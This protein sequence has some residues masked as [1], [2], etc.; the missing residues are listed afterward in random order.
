MATTTGPA[1]TI[2]LLIIMILIIG[3]TGRTVPANLP[4]NPLMGR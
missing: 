2:L 1:I 4:E 3:R